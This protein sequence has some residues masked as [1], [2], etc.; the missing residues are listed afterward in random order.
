MPTIKHPGKFEGELHLCERLWHLS[1]EGGCDDEIGNISEFGFYYCLIINVPL[2]DVSH[3]D[4]AADKYV[5]A[6]FREV[7]GT[8]NRVHAVLTET[9]QGF[10]HCEFFKTP[11]A[12]EARFREYQK[13]I[14]NLSDPD[15]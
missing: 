13:E 2:R 9:D 7:C 5:T 14:E 15:E 8:D 6:D 10:V 12:A 1:N 3:V 11:R 4:A